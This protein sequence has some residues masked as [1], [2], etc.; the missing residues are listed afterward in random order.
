MI[1]K[2]GVFMLQR[3]LVFGLLAPLALIG[4]CGSGLTGGSNSSKAPAASATGPT[5]QTKADKAELAKQVTRVTAPVS[6]S[7]PHLVAG[8]AAQIKQVTLAVNG[9]S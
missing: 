5:E 7:L 9:M 8:K 6:G 4:G 1:R 3:V 2:G